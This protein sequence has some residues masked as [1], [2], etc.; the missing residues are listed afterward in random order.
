MTSPTWPHRWFLTLPAF[1]RIT[2]IC[3]R[4]RHH[5][6]DPRAQGEAE[7]APW[8]WGTKTDCIGRGR[9]EAACRPHCPSSRTA[10]H[11]VERSPSSIRFLQ[12]EKRT[13]GERQPLP[14]VVGHVVGARTLIS[15]HGDYRG[16][17]GPSHRE[18]D[19]DRKGGRGSTCTWFLEDWVH[20]CRAQA[21][22]PTSGFAYPRNHDR[23]AP[24]NVAACRSAL[25]GSS[26]EEFCQ[27]ESLVCPCPGKVLSH[28]ARRYRECLPA[29]SD[30]KAGDNFWS[31][32]AQGCSCWEAG[33]QGWLPPERSQYGV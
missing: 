3:S 7:A 18:S 26:N 32:V 2:N 12:Q 21:V 22:I 20:T 29:P 8:N 1:T 24:E 19:C 30:Q 15:R 10:L 25:S 6:E 4:T 23:D 13:S 5:R 31:C 9:E 28:S 17:S 14:S 33:R 16:L 27:P 11:H